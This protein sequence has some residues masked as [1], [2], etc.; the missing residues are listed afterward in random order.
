MRL[1]PP[2][3]SPRS[4]RTQV[5]AVSAAP[6]MLPSPSHFVLP[7]LRRRGSFRPGP[8]VAEPPLPESI[9]QPWMLVSFAHSDISPPIVQTTSPHRAKAAP[10]ADHLVFRGLSP[11]LHRLSSHCADLTRHR[12]WHACSAFAW[13][14]SLLVGNPVAHREMHIITGEKRV[15]RGCRATLAHRLCA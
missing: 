15:H 2:R 1:I 5:P 6:P 8:A 7:S 4:Y 9:R 14:T 12:W 13:R 10:V 3:V 11:A